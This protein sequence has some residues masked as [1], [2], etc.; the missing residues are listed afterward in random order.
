MAALGKLEAK[1]K[2]ESLQLQCPSS[3][4]TER[5]VAKRSGLGKF[6]PALVMGDMQLGSFRELATVSLRAWWNQGVTCPRGPRSSSCTPLI[7]FVTSP[8]QGRQEGAYSFWLPRACHWPFSLPGGAG[9]SPGTGWPWWPAPSQVASENLGRAGNHHIAH[10][11]VS[12][13]SAPHS[14]WLPSGLIGSGSRAPRRAQGWNPEEQVKS[15]KLRAHFCQLQVFYMQ[16]REFLEVLSL[17][18]KKGV[19]SLRAG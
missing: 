9:G 16:S 17:L 14:C 8:S 6:I 1:L 7:R 2:P 11:V 18:T 10:T 15:R 5:D 12:T 13:V 3:F 4:P 19:R